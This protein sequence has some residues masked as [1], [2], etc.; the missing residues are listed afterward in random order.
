MMSALSMKSHRVD[1]VFKAV[2]TFFY[3]GGFIAAGKV[4]GAGRA[5]RGRGVNADSVK[6]AI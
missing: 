4:P 6:H 3:V 5:D 1:H 2:T